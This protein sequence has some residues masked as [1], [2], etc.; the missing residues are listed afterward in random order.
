MESGGLIAGLCALGVLILMLACCFGCRNNMP[1][2][3]D[4]RV[5][6]LPQYV[7]NIHISK[8]GV[9]FLYVVRDAPDLCAFDFVCADL[10]FFLTGCNVC[11]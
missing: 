4:L 9:R 7:S 6:L 11:V 8:R 2:T 5:P 1:I 10:Y 3:E